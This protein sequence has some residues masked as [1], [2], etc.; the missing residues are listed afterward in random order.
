MYVFILQRPLLNMDIKVPDMPPPNFDT[1]GLTHTLVVNI[2][3]LN[4]QPSLFYRCKADSDSEA[5]A[6]R[7]L[8][9]IVYVRVDPETGNKQ[10][11]VV[12]KAYF[13]EGD[14]RYRIIIPKHLWAFSGWPRNET[15]PLD[16]DWATAK[17]VVIDHNL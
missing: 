9:D 10:E 3:T 16:G 14:Q 7:A 13:V 12:G 8:C 4:G 11:V 17:W 6:N 5:S 1:S 2:S 15:R